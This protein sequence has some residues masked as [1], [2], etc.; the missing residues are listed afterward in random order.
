VYT[1]QTA[2]DRVLKNTATKDPRV[3]GRLSSPDHSV[4]WLAPGPPGP[5]GTVLAVFVTVSGVAVQEK[6][7][8]LIVDDD[9]EFQ[10]GLAEV[11]SREGFAPRTAADLAEARQQLAQDL[12]EVVLVDLHLPDGSGLD[13]LQ[14]LEGTGSPEVIVI[15]GQ[16]SLE[17]AVEALRCGA[18]DY[19]TKPVDFARIHT[20]LANLARTRDLKREIGSLRGELRKPGRFGMVG[21]SPS[22]QRVYDMVWKIARTDATVLVV[23]ETGT[24]KELVAQT[25]HSMSRRSKAPFVP[26]NCGAVAPTLIESELFG[27]ERGSFTGAERVH[28]GFFERANRGTLFLDE[29]TEMSQELQVKLLRVLETGSL[30]R[31][32]GS[33]LINLDVRVVAATNRRPEEAVAAGKLREDLLYRLNVLPV[34]LPPLH[35]R[36]D[37]VELLAEHFLDLL[38]KEGGTAKRFTEPALQRLRRHSWPGNVRE[39]RNVIQRAYILAEQDIDLDALPLGVEDVQSSGLV[40]KVGSS[41]AEAERRLVLATLEHF[42]G[43]KRKTAAVL[44]IS[45]KTLY[46]RLNMYRAAGSRLPAR[47]RVPAGERANEAAGAGEASRAGEQGGVGDRRRSG[48][49]LA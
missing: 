37:D 36:G 40:V 31:V 42:A 19:L 28:R 15:T 10:R 38:N 43:D 22:M 13:L 16:A 8:A 29:I 32:G 18:A 14:E 9:L 30:S 34:E 7:R 2:P 47:P 35:E 27:H 33:E 49:G 46:N 21:A 23:G 17:T 4:E 39:M 26:V 1:L 48:P 25:I 12:P 3:A 41:I 44:E 5:A 11:V 6:P 45:L 20:M 24:G